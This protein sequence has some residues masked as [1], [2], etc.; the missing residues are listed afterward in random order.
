MSPAKNFAINLALVIGL[1]VAMA[2]VGP[3]IDAKTEQ[4]Q[5]AIDAQQQVRRFTTAAQEACGPGAAWREQ[6]DGSIRCYLHNGKKT[7][8]VIKVSAL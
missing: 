8:T 7:N 2:Y 1:A 3:G 6:E 5:Q 4:V